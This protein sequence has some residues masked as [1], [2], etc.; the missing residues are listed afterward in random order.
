M[1]IKEVLNLFENNLIHENIPDSMLTELMSNIGNV[2]SDIR[3][4]T[5]ETICLLILNNK[6]TDIQVEKILYRSLKNLNID[7]GNNDSDSVFL[8]SFSSL[9]LASIVENDIKNKHFEK[10]IYNKIFNAAIFYYE[11]EQDIRGYILNKGWAH[12]IAHG[13][14]LISICIE[15]DFYLNTHNTTIM[16]LISNNLFKLTKDSLPY[17]DNEDERQVFIIE[18]LLEKG[19]SDIDLINWINDIQV[20]LNQ[21]DSEGVKYY[22]ILKNITDMYETLYFRLKFKNQC[23]KTQLT[24]E[25]KLEELF[26]KTYFKDI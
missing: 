26:L 14:D 4:K 7:L 16:N 20:K 1:N 19:L 5:T 3:E 6:L 13:S 21:I 12:S 2:D 15:S 22:R 24:I 8:R 11:K 17:I 10:G 9:I 23:K 18:S 25:S